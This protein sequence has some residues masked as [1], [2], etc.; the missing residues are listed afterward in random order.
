MNSVVGCLGIRRTQSVYRG[1]D[2]DAK[3]DRVTALQRDVIDM[4]QETERLHRDRAR[5]FEILGEYR[6]EDESGASVADI[7]AKR[8]AQLNSDLWQ[9]EATAKETQERLVREVKLL[10]QTLEVQSN[11]AQQEKED[12]D[13]ERGMLKTLLLKQQATKQIVQ[14]SDDAK[15]VTKVDKSTHVDLRLDVRQATRE[16]CIQ[17]DM[18][19]PRSLHESTFDSVVGSEDLTQMTVIPVGQY[20]TDSDTETKPFSKHDTEAVNCDRRVRNVQTRRFLKRLDPDNVDN[21]TALTFLRHQVVTFAE[22]FDKAKWEMELYQRQLAWI[23]TSPRV[24]PK[25]RLHHGAI[26]NMSDVEEDSRRWCLTSSYFGGGAKKQMLPPLDAPPMDIANG[27]TRV[28]IVP[29]ERDCLARNCISMVKCRRC[30]R[31]YRPKKNHRLGCKFHPKAQKRIEK[32]DVNGRL[33]RA[34]FIW[35]CCMQHVD[36]PGCNVGEHVSV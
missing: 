10:N 1:A 5:C 33:L 9:T 22:K 4:A 36:A 27:T 30:H 31:L 16:C 24:H 25:D 12:R 32:Y 6:D 18:G 29:S 20:E 21:K 2:T 35:E 7:L 14:S 26:Y 34:A 19:P 28:G 17:V 8:V 15:E 13:K 23:K 11:L 3:V